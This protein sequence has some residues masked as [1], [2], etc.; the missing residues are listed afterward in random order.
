MSSVQGL[1]KKILAGGSWPSKPTARRSSSISEA[2]EQSIRD[3]RTTHVKIVEYRK[4]NW[5][6][7]NDIQSS[8]GSQGGRTCEEISNRAEAARASD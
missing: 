1:L 2:L 4:G 7:K 3:K 6:G 8:S 5:D